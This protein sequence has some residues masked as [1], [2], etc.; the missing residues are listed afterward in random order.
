VIGGPAQR[1]QGLPKAE[2]SWEAS[3]SY[4]LN[5]LVTLQPDVQYIVNPAGG[6]GRP[7]ALAVGLRVQVEFDRAD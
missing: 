3:Y 7:D 6:P 1:A 4:Q 5:G 2:T